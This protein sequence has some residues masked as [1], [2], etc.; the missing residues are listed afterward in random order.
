MRQKTVLNAVLI[1]NKLFYSLPEQFSY[2]PMMK[3]GATAKKCN[4]NSGSYTETDLN[5]RIKAIQEKVPIKTACRQF[6]IP[7]STIKYRLSGKWSGK[8]KNKGTSNSTHTAGGN[9]YS[10]LD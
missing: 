6:R 9:R 8:K 10:M 4:K 3:K 7:R 2:R 5:K 1:T